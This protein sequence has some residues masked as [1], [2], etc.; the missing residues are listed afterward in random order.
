MA[1]RGNIGIVNEDGSIT[2]IY[3]HWDSYPEYVGKMLL[4]HYND[5]GIINELLDLGNLSILSESLYS[6]TGINLY[7]DNNRHTFN[8]PQDGVCVAYGRDRGDTGTNSRTFE[9]LGEYEHFGSVVD[10]QYLYDNGK[11]MYR[12]TY[13]KG[14]WS[15]LTPEICK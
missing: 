1:T 3:V 7:S 12:N 11:W 9:D 4:N 10:Y 8:N 13:G 2:A 14:G 5:V 15:D 6:T